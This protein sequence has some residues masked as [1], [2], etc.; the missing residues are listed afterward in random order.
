MKLLLL[1]VGDLT[2][3]FLLRISAPVPSRDASRS[4]QKSCSGVFF[5]SLWQCFPKTEGGPF[6]LDSSRVFGR[7]NKAKDTHTQIHTPDR[8]RKKSD[9]NFENIFVTYL[10][11][12][13]SLA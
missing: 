1:G 6:G 5:P 13:E 9:N 3:S 10:M 4:L 11:L 2:L 12:K 7:P 8:S